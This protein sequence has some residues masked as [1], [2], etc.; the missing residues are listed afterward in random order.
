M[1]AMANAGY[2][3]LVDFFPILRYV[4]KWFPGAGFKRNA[5]LWKVDVMGMVDIPWA[6]MK[7]P[8]VSLRYAHARLAFLSVL[9]LECWHVRSF[10]RF[11]S[12]IA[13]G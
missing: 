6:I 7:D 5:A 11:F 3:S 4:P 1:Q 12:S 10:R 8:L 9:F 2:G 13:A